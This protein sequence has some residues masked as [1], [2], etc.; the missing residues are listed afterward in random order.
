MC[1][2]CVCVRE[3]ERKKMREVEIQ[4]KHLILFDFLDILKQ[5][6]QDIKKKKRKKY[7]QNTFQ[8]REIKNNV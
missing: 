4:R 1:R 3:R 2:L 7:V 5:T 8:T 6:L